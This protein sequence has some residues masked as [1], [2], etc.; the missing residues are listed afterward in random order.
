MLHYILHVVQD[1]GHIV[2][3]DT[4]GR[5]SDPD[6][7]LQDNGDEDTADILLFYTV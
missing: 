2:Q 7:A 5:V 1:K 4:P 3:K 6:N